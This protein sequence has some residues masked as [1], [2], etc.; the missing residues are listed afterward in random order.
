MKATFV[1]LGV[2][3]VLAAAAPAVAGVTG[4]S[5]LSREVAVKTA[6]SPS[7]TSHGPTARPS[8]SASADDKGGLRQRD[9]KGHRTAEPGDDR[10]THTSG[11]HTSGTHTSGTHTSGTRP[12]GTHSSSTEAGDDH[13]GRRNRGGD[14][15]NSGKG[16][17]NSGKGSG[18]RGGSDDGPNH[19]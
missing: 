5:A 13:G 4:N 16:S 15:D 19:D 3:A 12:S 2:V 18:D 10:G 6:P 7:A 8:A 14:D 17:G 1:A 9:D 11:T